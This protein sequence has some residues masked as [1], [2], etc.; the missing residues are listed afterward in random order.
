MPILAGM[1]IANV[2]S[3]DVS[4]SANLSAEKPRVS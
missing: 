3:D 2:A 4:Q 1:A